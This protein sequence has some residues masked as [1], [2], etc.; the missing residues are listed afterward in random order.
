MTWQPKSKQNKNLVTRYFM[1]FFWHKFL[2]LTISKWR[3]LVKI[4]NSKPR[5]D[6]SVILFQ[7]G[8]CQQTDKN[9]SLIELVLGAGEI[10]KVKAFSYN[11]MIKWAIECIKDTLWWRYFMIWPLFRFWGRNLGT[12]KTSR[13]SSD[14]RR[15]SGLL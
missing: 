8:F 12:T 5:Q 14:L 3:G 11:T 6:N 15:R 1:H 13:S 4:L 10:N 2:I 7:K 9:Q